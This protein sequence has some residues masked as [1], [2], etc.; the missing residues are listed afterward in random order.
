MTASPSGWWRICRSVELLRPAIARCSVRG[1]SR[2]RWRMLNPSM[3]GSPMSSRSR[4]GTAVS[5]SSWSASMSPERRTWW[6]PICRASA[7]MRAMVGSSSTRTMSANPP[8]LRR[9]RLGQPISELPADHL[10][11]ARLGQAV[12]EVDL[13]G[14]LVLGQPLAAEGKDLV[15]GGR[16]APAQDDKRDHLLAVPRVGPADDGG[17]GHCWVLE[18]HLFDIAGVHVQPA[19]DDHVLLAVDDIEVAVGVHAADVAG[20]QPAV[21]NRLGG[22]VRHPVVA[23]HDIGATN[24]DF[25]ELANRNLTVVLVE[26]LDR[27]AG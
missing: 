20:V 9:G 15:R 19:A 22:D 26:D 14:R 12:Q 3:P 17:L 24:A 13:F 5:S 11:H 16:G 6:P 8:S 25:A 7:Y 4:S 2:S 10:A 1:S 27:E 21:A 23:L 18:Q